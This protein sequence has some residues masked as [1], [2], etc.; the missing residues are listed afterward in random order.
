[1][2]ARAHRA[3]G[4]SQLLYSGPRLSVRSKPGAQPSVSSAMY[5][6]VLDN[7]GK[8]VGAAKQVFDKVGAIAGTI[9]IY[10]DGMHD[11]EAGFCDG[12]QIRVR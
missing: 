2:S 3:I 4:L 12:C 6:Y 1:M 7:A 10:W 8:V 11:L 9:K 5:H